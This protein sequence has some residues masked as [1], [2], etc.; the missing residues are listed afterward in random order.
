ML[1]VLAAMVAMAFG[2]FT[3]PVV[4]PAMEADLLDSYTLAG[5]LGTVNLTAYL[6]GSLLVSLLA[7]R[8]DPT[9]LVQLGLGASTL[10]LVTLSVAPSAL[11]LGAGLALTG[12]GGALIWISAPVLASGAVDPSRRGLAIGLVGAGIGVGLVCVSQFAAVVRRLD[13]PETWRPVWIA[14]AVVAG[15][16][17]AASAIWLRSRGTASNGPRLRLA[18]LRGV[19]GWKAL[20]G[21]YVAYAVTLTVV[22]QYL[23]AMLE[24]DAG[25]GSTHSSAVFTVV[26]ASGVIGAIV[27]GRVSDAVGRRAVLVAEFAL[28]AAATLVLLVREEPWT[29]VGAVLF[30]LAM[31]GVPGLVAAYLGDHL[32]PAAFA[33]AFGGITLLFGLGQLLAP[34]VGGSLADRTGA[35]TWTFL[36]AAAAAVA[37]TWFAWQLPSPSLGRPLQSPPSG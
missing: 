23:V 24:D 2:R 36:L 20:V 16:L 10:G 18:A 6:A 3:Y 9:R 12:F 21:A 28:L 14:E 7:G 30:G 5:F 26:A 33:A 11:V 31:A 15:V 1:S 34:Q 8:L 29:I 25:F 27:A 17:V 22:L 19:P 32:E 37:G 4:L 35:F 13:G